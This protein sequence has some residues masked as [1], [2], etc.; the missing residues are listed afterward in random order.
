MN[1]INKKQPTCGER[2]LESALSFIDAEVRLAERKVK[3]LHADQ[4]LSDKAITR[5]LKDLGIQR[6]VVVVYM[7]LE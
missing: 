6:F 3:E 1:N 5:S 2:V 4:D 7:H